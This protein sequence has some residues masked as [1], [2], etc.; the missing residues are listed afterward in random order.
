[1]QVVGV[2]VAADCTH[3]SIESVSY[4]HLNVRGALRGIKEQQFCGLCDV[5]VLYPRGS[6]NEEASYDGSDGSC[7]LYTS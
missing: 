7:L 4:T 5:R 2:F 6:E 3:I 1:M